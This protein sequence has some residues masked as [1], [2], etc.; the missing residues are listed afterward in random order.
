MATVEA[1][2]NRMGIITRYPIDSRFN[3]IVT[4]I[5]V[6][7]TKD[8]EPMYVNGVFYKH[9]PKIRQEDISTNTATSFVDTILLSNL[10]LP[11]AGADYDGDTVTIKIAYT[12]EANKEL[13]EFVKKK[14]NFIDLDGG[15][16]RSSSA[17]VIQSLYSLTK[18]L[19]DDKSKLTQPTFK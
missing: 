2:K 9:Y 19:D 10:Y 12:D 18:I 5:D 13:Q 1:A 7:S 16:I 3:S 8:T 6:A 15:S 4:E 11:G 14:E 17:D